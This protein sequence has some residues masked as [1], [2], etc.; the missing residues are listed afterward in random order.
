MR[1]ITALPFSFLVFTCLSL[2]L[3]GAQAAEFSYDEIAKR[4]PEV[5]MSAKQ[6]ANAEMQGEC[7]VGLKQLNFKSKSAF[8]PVAEWTNYR[9][10][11]LLDQLPPCEVLLIMEV[12]QKKLRLMQK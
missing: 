9:T 8:D 6:I 12:A 4:Y 11:S 3:T 7:L 10:I 2:S 1:M 5:R